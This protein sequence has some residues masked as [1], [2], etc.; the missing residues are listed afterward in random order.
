MAALTPVSAMLDTVG[1]AAIRGSRVTNATRTPDV[2][3][4]F[5]VKEVR[6]LCMKQVV[7]WLLNLP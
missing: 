4:M 3:M 5:D 6:I 1:R 2:F 7:K